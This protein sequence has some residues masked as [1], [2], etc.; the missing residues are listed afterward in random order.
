MAFLRYM[1]TAVMSKPERFTNPAWLKIENVKGAKGAVTFLLTQKKRRTRK[2]FACF[3]NKA[4]ICRFGK[5]WRMGVCLPKQFRLL[6]PKRR[7]LAPSTSNPEK[8]LTSS[9]PPAFSAD[10]TAVCRNKGRINEKIQTVLYTKFDVLSIR[11][12]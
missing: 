8:Q 5:I 4:S 12:K 11:K 10:F 6:P 7:P 3:F 9:H 2:S 1:A